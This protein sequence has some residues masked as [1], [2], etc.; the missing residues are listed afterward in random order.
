MNCASGFVPD[1]D[2]RRL[3]GFFEP[4]KDFRWDSK[5]VVAGAIMWFIALCLFFGGCIFFIVVFVK[6]KKQQSLPP[7]R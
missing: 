1:A 7:A 3:A 2:P 4:F 6:A 5:G